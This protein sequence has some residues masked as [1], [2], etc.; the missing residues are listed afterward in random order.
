MKGSANVLNHDNNRS[1]KLAHRTEMMQ[2]YAVSVEESA[3]S[4]RAA[5]S[6]GF[7]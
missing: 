6:W 2:I 1:Q 4:E 3:Q 7:G 5:P